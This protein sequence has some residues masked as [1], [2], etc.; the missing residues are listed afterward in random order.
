MAQFTV[1]KIALAGITPVFNVA[2]V[3]GDTFLNNGRTYLHVKNGGVA[4]ITVTIDSKQLSNY[5][6]DVDITVSIP[7]GSERVIGLLDT[8]RFNATTGLVNVAYSGVTSVSVAV[9][10]Y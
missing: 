1:Q 8:G 3:G 9:I 7:A 2:S 6:T 10:S 5:G 4:A